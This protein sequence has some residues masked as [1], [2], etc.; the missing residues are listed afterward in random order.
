VTLEATHSSK[1]SRPLRTIEPERADRWIAKID[2]I[3]DMCAEDKRASRDTIHRLIAAQVRLGKAIEK[4]EVHYPY[5]K[6][7]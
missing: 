4:I 6:D 1:V 7:I 5:L 2:D 3:A